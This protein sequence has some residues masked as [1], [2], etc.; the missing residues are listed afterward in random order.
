MV[1]LEDP[2]PSSETGVPWRSRVVQVVLVSTALAPLGV[3]LV[4]PA[5]PVFRD[6]FGLSDAQ[7][8]LLVSGYFAVGILLAPFLG[9]LADRLGRKRVLAGGLATFGLV[10]GAIAFAP[11]FE[12]VVLFRVLQGTAAAAIF[13]TTVTIIGDRFEGGQRTAVFGA[14]VA[15]LSGGA[16][17]YPVVG[18]F[19]A[20]F[21]W[22]AP[23]L[24]Y[25]L[26]VPV[27]GF[28]LVTL[29]EPTTAAGSQGMAYLRDALTVL[30]KP[31]TL[32]LFGATFL[33]EFLSFGVV[34]T[35]LPFL[36]APSLTLVGIGLVL[37]VAEFVS[38]AVAAASGRLTRWLSVERLIGVGF[39]CYAVGFLGIWLATRPLFVTTAA[40]FV[41][42][43]IGLLLPNI[44]ASLMKQIP[45]SYRA[46]T[47]SFRTSTTFLGR[48]A[49]PVVFVGVAVTAGVG[50]PPLLLSASAIALV[51]AVLSVPML[52]S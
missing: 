26:A 5:L 6:H 25:F 42:A 30:G 51:A 46:R 8:S 20:G 49:G 4:S 22:T 12:V 17:L 44:D 24:L 31:S 1:Q 13:I 41:G 33:A 14:N 52:E 15:I 21:D 29:E 10:G 11:A 9:L 34:F 37:L 38:M 27:A 23:F 18:G 2:P 19:L 7:T 50:Y 47:M 32:S 43:G 48:A 35:A 16:A 45:A 28:A 39:A 3:P 40:V 36:L